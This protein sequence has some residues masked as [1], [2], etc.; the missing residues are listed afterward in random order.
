MVGEKGSLKAKA[1]LLSVEVSLPKLLN[2]GSDMLLQCQGCH[3]HG[4]CH[5]AYNLRTSPEKSFAVYD[6]VSVLFSLCNLIKIV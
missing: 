2:F 6:S 3:F 1:N 4:N 5:S